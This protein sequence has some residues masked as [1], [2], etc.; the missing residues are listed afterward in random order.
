MKI[1][2]MGCLCLAPSLAFADGLRSGERY[3]E[4]TVMNIQDC[5][6]GAIAALPEEGF[7][8]IA[9][10]RANPMDPTFAMAWQC[11]TKL[12]V[13]G[14]LRATSIVFHTIGLCSIPVN[15]AV[16]AVMEAGGGILNVVDFGVS[17]VPC[18]EDPHKKAHEF[19]KMMRAQGYQC[20][21]AKAVFEE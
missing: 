15:P 20:D 7:G 13:Q 4:F 3:G 11:G 9:A 10:L 6:P 2:W 16:T 1:W 18:E 5:R 17:F 12:A 19:C 8:G 21:P 14:G